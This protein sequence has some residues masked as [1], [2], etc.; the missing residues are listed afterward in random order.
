MGWW[1]GVGQFLLLV[2]PTSPSLT[3][4]YLITDTLRLQSTTG[5]TAPV[6]SS[7]ARDL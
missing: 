2:L 1:C 6:F 4:A 5:P 3:L 7:L